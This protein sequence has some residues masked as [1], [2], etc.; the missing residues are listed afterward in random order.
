MKPFTKR[1]II[2]L[3]GV[4]I[5]LGS[6]FVYHAELDSVFLDTDAMASEARPD[7]GQIVKVDK[8]KVEKENINLSILIRK[9][10]ELK[11]REK[12]LV[13][14]EEDL[15][16]FQKEINNKI[17]ELSQLRDEINSKVSSS[18]NSERNKLKHLIKIYSSMKPQRA[19][20][21]IEKLD[22]KFAVKL[23]SQMKGEAVGSILSFVEIETAAK[24]SEG[25]ADKN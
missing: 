10:D 25:L 9:R 2:A 15:V 18:S 4:K 8:K 13:K 1:L 21:L 11:D 23:L 20:G 14:K 6:V 7:P 22:M 5:L 3:I 19:A 24:I 17:K 12:E 16:I